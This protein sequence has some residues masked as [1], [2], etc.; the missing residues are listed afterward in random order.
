MVMVVVPL[1][2]VVVVGGG[3][4]TTLVWLCI[5]TTHICTYIYMYICA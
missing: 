5:Y 1:I 3:E 2:V 4:E